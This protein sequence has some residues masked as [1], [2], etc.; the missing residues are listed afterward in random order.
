MKLTANGHS[1]ADRA[2]SSAY[3][4]LQVLAQGWAQVSAQTSREVGAGTGRLARQTRALRAQ[5]TLSGVL[6]GR[7]AQDTRQAV[8]SRHRRPP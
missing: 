1:T 2:Y 8:C 5:E 6:H 7:F 3:T 4:I